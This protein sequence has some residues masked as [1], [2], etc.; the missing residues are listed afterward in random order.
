ME[1]GEMMQP[2]II[3]AAVMASLIASVSLAAPQKPVKPG[4]KPAKEQVNVDA[5]KI[6]GPKKTG[7]AEREFP[8]MFSIAE[9]AQ[10]HKTKKVIRDK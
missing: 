7:K 10:T 4:E 6:K 3:L 2:A 5:K 9:K 8:V 1:G